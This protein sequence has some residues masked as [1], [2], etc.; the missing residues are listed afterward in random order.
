MACHA[1]IIKLQIEEAFSTQLFFSVPNEISQIE[2]IRDLFKHIYIYIY[3]YIY[4]F[5]EYIIDDKMMY[6]DKSENLSV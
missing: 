4:I 3:T 5:I 1:L 2:V 6:L